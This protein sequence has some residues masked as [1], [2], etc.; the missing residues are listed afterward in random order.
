VAADPRRAEGLLNEVVAAGDV[1]AGAEALGYLYLADTPLRDLAKAAAA[2][3]RA[4]Q[5]GSSGAMIELA[6]L[7]TTGE[8]VPAD[9]VRAETLLNR[10][11]AAGAVAA[12]AR[13][14]GDLYRANTPLRNAAKAAAAYQR[15]AAAGDARAKLRLAGVLAEAE[16]AA[17]DPRRAEALLQEVAASGE[18][19][20]ATALGDLYRTNPTLRDAAKAM[21][22]Y[23]TAADRGDTGAKVRLAIMLFEGDGVAADPRRAEGLLNE[24]V[25]AGDVEAGAEALGYLYLA[26][27]PLRNAAK[28]A[29]A[30][31]RAAAAGDV[32]ASIVLIRQR[33]DLLTSSSERRVFLERLRSAARQTGAD[34]IVAEVMDLP[35]RALAFLIQE[36]FVQ[37]GSGLNPTGN[38]GPATSRLILSFCRANA[39]EDCRT[40]HPSP[41]LVRKLLEVPNGDHPKL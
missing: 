36:A 26:D 14:L 9:A 18:A 13:A 25:A 33:P 17:A 4:A 34:E 8:G 30:Y 6:Q 7:L 16:G 38:L 28:A 5:A 21:A 31:Q 15:A 1:E 40:A 3:E 35:P 20:A 39:I 23:R 29:A 11:V 22:A 19:G 41:G 37:A 2:F 27:T 24:V 32:R 12:G 10:A